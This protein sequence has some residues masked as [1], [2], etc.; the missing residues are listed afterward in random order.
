MIRVYDVHLDHIESDAK[1]Q[2]MQ[3][4]LDK[5]AEDQQKIPAETI[6]LGDFNEQPDGLAITYINE[7]KDMKL[8]D[9]TAEIPATWHDFGK[10]DPGIKIDYIFTSEG[11]AGMVQSVE[12]WNDYRNGIYLSDHYPVS[13]VISME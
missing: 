13:A 1:A 9:I 6:L 7:R 11:L 8:V 4:V 10:L 3:V 12:V 5:I 2:G